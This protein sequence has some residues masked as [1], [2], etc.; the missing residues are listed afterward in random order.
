MRY[1][2]ESCGGVVFFV[3]GR[4]RAGRGEVFKTENLRLLTLS[5]A[6]SRLFISSSFSSTLGGETG[7]FVCLILVFG[8]A[9]TIVGAGMVVTLG[10]VAGLVSSASGGLVVWAKIVASFRRASIYFPATGGNGVDGCGF[11]SASV[12]FI[13]ASRASSAADVF[14]ILYRCGKTRPSARSVLLWSL[15]CSI[16]GIDN[17]PAPDRGTNLRRR[18]APKYD[19]RIAPRVL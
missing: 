18:G 10:V 4:D 14:G 2:P 6:A 12:N 1:G 13:A 19:G 5:E 8:A 15:R 9:F 16:G 7:R 3:V 17:V 11:R